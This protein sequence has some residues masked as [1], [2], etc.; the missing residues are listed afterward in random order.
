MRSYKKQIFDN[1][2]AKN[3]VGSSKDR[4]PTNGGWIELWERETGRSRRTCSFLGCS[5][6]AEVGGH[7]FVRDDQG[8]PIKKI[9]IA[10][11]CYSCNNSKPEYFG[12]KK[13]TACV[14]IID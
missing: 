2:E 4:A 3:C 12:L 5:E 9:F 1:H 14:E 13:N 6:D 11:I 10:A 8:R 7:I